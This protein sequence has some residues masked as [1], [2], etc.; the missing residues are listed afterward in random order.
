MEARKISVY[1]TGV[2]MERFQLQTP[3]LRAAAR[4]T[5]NVSSIGELIPRKAHHI[6]TEAILEIDRAMLVIV[7]EGPER[8]RL[9][10]LT[11]AR[12]LSGRVRLLGN[13]PH[14]EVPALLAA[15]DVM[16]LASESEGLANSWLEAL[17]CGTPVVIPDADGAKEVLNGFGA[18]GRLV[19]ERS[20]TVFARVIRAILTDP[21]AP[22][23]VR[24]RGTGWNTKDLRQYP[25][26][27]ENSRPSVFQPL[28]H[29]AVSASS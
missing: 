17:A 5:L 19:Q 7:G 25:S 1:Y 27:L 14:A 24:V 21:P 10:A 12:G 6:L 4:T 23:V 13:V 20:P 15:A 16:A 18:P 28:V 29:T 3:Q 11:Q 9:T 2:D 26:R 8:S 22:A